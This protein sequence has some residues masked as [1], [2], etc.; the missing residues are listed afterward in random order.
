MIAYA[1]LAGESTGALFMA[2][3]IPGLLLIIIMAVYAV[4]RS[5]RTGLQEL[6]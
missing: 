3:V 1:A 5:I 2:G 6:A 4:V